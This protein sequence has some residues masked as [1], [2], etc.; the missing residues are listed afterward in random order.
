MSL[1]NILFGKNHNTATILAA[2]NLTEGV[3][4]R[5]RDVWIEE[6]N[7]RIV[8][9]TRAGGGNRED[10]PNEILTQHP[11]YLYDE[12]DAFD[13]TYAYYYFAMPEA[14]KGGA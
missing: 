13:S 2:L 14:L 7:N 8:I 4:E 9:Y 6:Y 10:Y 5:F 1:Y 11:L 3:I 12:D